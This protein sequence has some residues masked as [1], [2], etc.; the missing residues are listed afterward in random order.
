MFQ[1]FIH[2]N[3]KHLIHN[4]WDMRGDSKSF[5]LFVYDLFSYHEHWLDTY[6]TGL[7]G[8]G[9][10]ITP[11]IEKHSHLVRHGDWG[12]PTQSWSIFFSG[13]KKIYI[14][15]YIT[16]LLSNQHGVLVYGRK[17][18]PNPTWIIIVTTCKSLLQPKGIPT[19]S[20][21]ALMDITWY[22]F[23]H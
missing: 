20:S 14:S 8:K 21:A 7:C 22:N 23:V 2:W 9:S 4:I 12:E 3:C 5:I 18:W 10:N 13:N 1:M 19:T 11:N 6:Y 16:F 17:A 15:L